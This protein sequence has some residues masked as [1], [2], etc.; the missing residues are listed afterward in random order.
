VC[1]D[2][3]ASAKR[4]LSLSLR[5]ALTKFVVV[6]VDESTRSATAF[7]VIRISKFITVIRIL[8][9]NMF[10]EASCIFNARYLLLLNGQMIK[11]LKDRDAIK[12]QLLVQLCGIFRKTVSRAS[13]HEQ[14]QTIC[15]TETLAFHLAC[16]EQRIYKHDFVIAKLFVQINEECD[17]VC[18]FVSFSR[19]LATFVLQVSNDIL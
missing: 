4:E 11:M 13:K 17:V 16:C 8:W 12:V 7:S 18:L 2:T 1:S 15:N 10:V 14:M 6:I 5:R 9:N 3:R 19:I